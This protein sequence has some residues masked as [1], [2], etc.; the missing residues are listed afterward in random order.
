M[1][2]YPE[3][4]AE[5]NRLGLYQWLTGS[6]FD[7]GCA[8][9][10]LRQVVGNGRRPGGPLFLSLKWRTG[11]LFIMSGTMDADLQNLGAEPSDRTLLNVQQMLNGVLSRQ[12]MGITII[13][14]ML[15][16][17][18]FLLLLRATW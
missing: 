16:R 7:P 4:I 12:S 17:P 2:L 8:V 5:I 9:V 11:E 13:R 3:V 15:V 18:C 1:Q 10:A 6:P 14:S